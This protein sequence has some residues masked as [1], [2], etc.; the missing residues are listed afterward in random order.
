M[1]SCKSL[2]IL[3]LLL[4]VSVGQRHNYMPCQPLPGDTLLHRES[5][6]RSFKLFGY[7]SETVHFD[8]GDNIIGCVHALDRW[9]DGTGGYAEFVGGGIGYN[10]VDVK[11]TSKWNRG[12]SFVIEVYGQ[13]PPICKYLRKCCVYFRTCSHTHIIPAD[14]L[15]FTPKSFRVESSLKD[16]LIC[17]NCL[18]GLLIDKL[19]NTCTYIGT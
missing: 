9:G 14:T 6:A 8:V 16:V 13:T 10:Y 17:R 1:C 2:V 12:F 18:C 7:V 5:S 4:A 19:M 11:I 15:R 3:L